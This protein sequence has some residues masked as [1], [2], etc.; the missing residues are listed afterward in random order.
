MSAQE[1][2]VQRP[3][4]SYWWLVA[5]ALVLFAVL[6]GLAVLPRLIDPFGEREVDRSQPVLL[7]RIRELSRYQAARGEFQVVIDLE[8]DAPFLPASVLGE[9]TLFVAAGSVDAYVDF[10]TMSKGAIRVSEDG[11]SAT[12]RLPHSRLDKVNLDQE[13]SY[14]F[15][16]RRGVLNRL[17]ELVTGS[18]S[19]E[20][21]LYVL[22][23]RKIMAAAE[24]S[25]LEKKAEQNTRSMLVG[26]LGSLGYSKVTVQFGGPAA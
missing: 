18:R 19:N 25:D 8:K 15:E 10:S 2:D 24:R 23:E 26:M 13:R 20:Q 7:E 17:G 16:A 14:V 21:R 1:P 5:A 3:A 11:R 22:A 4:R 9:R 6:A 12:V